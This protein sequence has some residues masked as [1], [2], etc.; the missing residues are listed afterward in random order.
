[1]DTGISYSET[2]KG[3]STSHGQTRSQVIADAIT[4]ALLTDRPVKQILPRVLK[5]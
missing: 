2:P 5:K 1:M 4:E 3:Q